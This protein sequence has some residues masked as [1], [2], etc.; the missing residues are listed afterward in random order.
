MLAWPGPLEAVVQPV[1]DV[2]AAVQA[3][4]LPPGPLPPQGVDPLQV[5]HVGWSIGHCPGMTAA[6]WSCLGLRQPGQEAAQ[7]GHGKLHHKLLEINGRL[8]FVWLLH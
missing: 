6:T 3:D 8:H 7:E 4:L 5:G 2:D 1:P